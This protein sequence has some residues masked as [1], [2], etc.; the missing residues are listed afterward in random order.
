MMVR[1]SSMLESDDGGGGNNISPTSGSTCTVL[2]TVVFC[3]VEKN[4]K[5]V[6]KIDR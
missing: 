6:C 1:T 5:S 2:F 3:F 4:D